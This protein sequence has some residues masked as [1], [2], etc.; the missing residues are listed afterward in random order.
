MRSTRTGASSRESPRSFYAGSFGP[1]IDDLFTYKRVSD[2]GI[3]G[4]SD[5][6]AL[7]LG[8]WRPDQRIDANGWLAELPSYV[9]GLPF[10]PSAPGRYMPSA[11]LRR[12]LDDFGS[13]DQ[14]FRQTELEFDP[15][16]AR[17]SGS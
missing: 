16:R 3:G 8:P 1:L 2:V 11:Q 15:A 7:P 5:T 9:I 14:N 6:L 10:R 13:F 12:H 17:T 4:V